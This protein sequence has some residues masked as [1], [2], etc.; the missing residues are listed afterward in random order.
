[1]NISSEFSLQNQK[2][3]VKTAITSEKMKTEVCTYTEH[4]FF[5]SLQ[6]QKKRKRDKKKRKHIPRFL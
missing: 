2:M 3:V 5:M 1:M 6:H 4:N